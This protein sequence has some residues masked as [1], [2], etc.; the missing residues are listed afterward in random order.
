MNYTNEEIKE[1]TPIEITHH[2]NILK[3]GRFEAEEFLSIW[4][5]NLY[6]IKWMLR[7]GAITNISND[8]FGYLL[9]HYPAKRKAINNLKAL[10][11]VCKVKRAQKEEEIEYERAQ[12]R[13]YIAEQ[14]RYKEELDEIELANKLFEDM[15]NEYEAWGNID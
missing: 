5:K 3:Q 9:K 6:Y 15:M 1:I 13:E 7:L 4:K 2:T 8:V 11:A 12:L 14:R 10:L